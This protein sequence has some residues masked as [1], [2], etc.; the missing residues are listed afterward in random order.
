[1]RRW[2]TGETQRNEAWTGPGTSCDG[3]SSGNAAFASPLGPLSGL[4]L[5]FSRKSG[6]DDVPPAPLGRTM[7]TGEQDRLWGKAK[8]ETALHTIARRVFVDASRVWRKAFPIVGTHTIPD[9]SEVVVS[10]RKSEAEARKL[11]MV[12]AWTDNAVIITD[13]LGTIE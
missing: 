8:G 10:L 4:G 5:D 12:A 6:F 7:P 11:A 1:M 13:A 2:I 3:P 9:E